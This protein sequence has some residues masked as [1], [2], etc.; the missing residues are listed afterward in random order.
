MYWD[1]EAQE[2]LEMKLPEEFVVIADSWSI[3]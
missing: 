2:E 1:R 3:K